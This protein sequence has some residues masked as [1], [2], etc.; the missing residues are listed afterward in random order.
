MDSNRILL[1]RVFKSSREGLKSTELLEK[2][3]ISEE[4]RGTLCRQH[5]EYRRFNDAAAE[6]MNARG[7]SV[8]IGSPFA[9]I[10][11]EMY[12]NW[13]TVSDKSDTKIAELIMKS[14]VDGLIEGKK[15]LKRNSAADDEVIRLANTFVD[16][17][18]ANFDDMMRFL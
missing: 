18:K 13:K 5:E 1:E 9:E 3:D 8:N 12:M 11:S 7:Y 10:S 4:I 15:L 16:R 2:M 17:E 6:I 14:N